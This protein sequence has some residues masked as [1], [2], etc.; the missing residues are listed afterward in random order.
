VNRWWKIT[1]NALSSAVNASELNTNS[2]ASRMPLITAPVPRKASSALTIAAPIA[3]TT[4][5][6]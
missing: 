5:S 4:M 2:V 3:G 1:A 6:A